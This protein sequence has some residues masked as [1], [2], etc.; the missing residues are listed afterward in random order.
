MTTRPP[1]HDRGSPPTPR[2]NRPV[3]PPLLSLSG[4]GVR[5]GRTPVLRGLDLELVPG[6]VIGIRGSNGSGKTTLLRVA[7]TLLRPDEGTGSVL[8]VELKNE[9]RLDV[10]RR[11]GLIGHGPAL[12]PELTLAENTAFVAR[13][14]RQGERRVK[15]VLD[16]VGLSRASGRRAS[17]CSFGMQRR[18]E[19]ARILLL[20]PDLLLFDEA[21]AGLD[22]AAVELVDHV[23]KTVQARRG[24]ALVVSHQEDWTAPLS[25]RMLELNDGKLWEIA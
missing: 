2:Y 18:A 6:E 16:A 19:F 11:I 25:D 8:G 5:L 1:R 20:E 7:A 21:H 15:E 22:P 17:E 10:R 13:F 9:N 3:A 4:V 24:G 12:Y 14:V 23:V